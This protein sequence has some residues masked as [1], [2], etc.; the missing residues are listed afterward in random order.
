MKKALFYSTYSN[1]LIKFDGLQKEIK[2]ETNL[3]FLFQDVTGIFL[4]R[5]AFSYLCVWCMMGYWILT[6]CWMRSNNNQSDQFS[7]NC[8][9]GTWQEILLSFRMQLP[10][11]LLYR[12]TSFP[13]LFIE[14]RPDVWSHFK[15][16]VCNAYPIA[17]YSRQWATIAA[18]NQYFEKHLCQEIIM[19]V[20]V[21]INIAFFLAHLMENAIQFYR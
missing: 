5:L 13:L 16:P 15:V 8:P 4:S 2:K 7:P 6:T 14:S 21:R 10:C 9:H 19:L 1:E 11:W 3:V 18:K 17:K 12:V 20:P